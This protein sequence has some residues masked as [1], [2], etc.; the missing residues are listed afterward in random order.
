M[1]EAYG[2][3]IARA[4]DAGIETVP[5]FAEAVP[6]GVVELGTCSSHWSSWR[7]SVGPWSVYQEPAWLGLRTLGAMDDV[8]V[9]EEGNEVEKR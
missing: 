9:G 5:A 1:R 7:E 6:M 4:F 8:V 2:A 3:M